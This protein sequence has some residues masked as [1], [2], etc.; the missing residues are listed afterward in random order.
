[1]LLAPAV[2]LAVTVLAVFSLNRLGLPVKQFGLALAISF[3]LAAIVIFWRLRPVFPWRRYFPF[4]A[5][6]LLA[7]FLTGRP[8]LEFGFDWL[9]YCSDDMAN[10]VLAA[11]RFFNHGFSELPNS[12]DLITGRDYSLDYWFFHVAGGVRPGSDLVI[13]WVS[14]LTGLSGNQ[15]FMPLIVAFQL[16]LTS[17]TGA[18]V[19]Q[20]RR[21][22]RAA[23][24]TCL[25]LTFSALTSL[26]TI[27]QLI[28]QVGGLSLLTACATLLM[29]PYYALPWRD[30]LHKAASPALVLASLFI[31]YPEVL[32]FL[33][34]ALGFYLVLGLIQHRQRW[35]SLLAS[36]GTIGLAVALLLNTYLPTSL[37]FLL[38]QTSQGNSETARLSLFPYFLLPSGLANL[39]GF[40]SLTV[41]IAEPWLS[42][43]ILGGGLLLL[44][45]VLYIIRQSWRRQPAALLSG[46]IVVVT[47][48]FFLKGSDFSLFKLAMFSQPFL[49][50]TLVV[51]WTDF[52]FKPLRLSKVF[53]PAVLIAMS[54]F[55]VLTQAVYVEAS[56]GFVKDN[57]ASILNASSS[58]ILSEFQETLT[59]T[60]SAPLVLDDDNLPLTKLQTIYTRGVEASLFRKVFANIVPEKQK[61][62]SLDEETLKKNQELLNVVNKSYFKGTFN[63]LD[64]TASDS[65]SNF[66]L[67]GPQNWNGSKPYLVSLTA[68][69]SLFNRWGHKPTTKNFEAQPLDEVRNHL[70]F[71][72]SELGQNYYLGEP[73]KI[74]FYQLENDPFFPGQTLSAIGRYFVFQAVNPAAEP[75]LVLNMT[76]TARADGESQLPPAV[77]IGSQRLPISMVGRGSARVFSPILTP[78]VIN[79]QPYF[80]LDMGINGTPFPFNRTGLMN[81]YSKNVLLDIRQ[82]VGFG[83]DISLVSDEQYKDM[84]A[85]EQVSSFP[86]DLANPNLEYSGMYED[87]WVSEAAFFGLNRP[88]G[89]AALVIRGT[90]PQIDSPDFRTEV[91]VLVDGQEIARRPLGLGDFELKLPASAQIGR[92]RLDLRFSYFQRLPGNDRR[93]VAA[94]LRSVGF[95]RGAEALDDVIA[96]DSVMR[97]GQGWYALETQNGQPFRW[98]NN[99]AELVI[100]RPVGSQQ[101]LNLE[102]EPGPG[103]GSQPFQLE[104]LDQAGKVVA[105]GR[106]EGRKTLLL[107]LPTT[108]GQPNLFR[109]QVKSDNKTAPN[110]PRILN[111]RVFNIKN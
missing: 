67:T 13:A 49:L 62:G 34:L 86:A 51:A 60:Q 98:V 43:S 74:S 18:M 35:P 69:Q 58:R 70:I 96:A 32:P 27:Y 105:T 8:L 37:S 52:S 87:G 4:G 79:N 88:E 64:Q 111:F 6:F 82:L 57:F 14:S 30:R 89:Q 77:A 80:G 38:A 107:D 109:L 42:L 103:L 17:A 23:F 65:K 54:L 11:Q 40:Q 108:P 41:F 46:V 1:M 53:G 39:W 55:S 91:T 12:S 44:I 45:A 31:V 99:Q 104:V 95:V 33:F 73:G 94:F 19:C 10:Y 16:I 100:N 66:I 21:L 102:L 25:V 63:L 83:R 7:L 93:P 28:G 90:V 47:V 78:Q 76:A 92:H 15:V 71:V 2:G 22:R 84:T 3:L 68:Q 26:G 106:A 20:F 59:K 61:Q 97:L 81:L 9:A 72:F 110:D 56:R 50:A 85:P 36:L 29:R 24:L 75:R 48:Y 101:S 5:V